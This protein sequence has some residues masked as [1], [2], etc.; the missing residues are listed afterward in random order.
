MNRDYILMIDGDE[1]DYL[2]LKA[3]IND[4][5]EGTVTL[6]WYQRD[7][8]AEIMICSGYYRLAMIEYK[9]G[10]ENGLETIRKVKAKCPEQVVFLMTSWDETTISDDQAMQA[11]ANGILRKSNL[12]KDLVKD[13]L[14]QY[15]MPDRFS[16]EE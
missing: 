5:F 3:L 14:S 8:I 9:F 10:T 2:L 1:D 13:T 16:S 15:M 6:D 12:S 11:G 7:G 4:V